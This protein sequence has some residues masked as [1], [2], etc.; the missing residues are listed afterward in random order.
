MSTPGRRHRDVF[1]AIGAGEQL[2]VDVGRRH[3]DHE[4]IGAG[5]QRRRFRAGIAGSGDQHD[6]LVV[7][8][9]ERALERGILRAGKAHIDDARALAHRPVDALEDIERGAL[10][11]GGVAGEGVH[12]KQTRGRRRPQHRLARGHRACHAG[13]MRVRLLRRAYRAEALRHH[14]HEVGMRGVDFRIDHR[15]RDVGAPDHAVDIQHL[16]LLEDVLRGV[17]LCWPVS[18]CAAGAWSVAAWSRL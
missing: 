18:P 14:A 2:V 10:G 9:L 15:D 17:A 7:G 4:R 16:E 1:A 6:A 13:A 11:L 12:G 5:E 8:E 3:R